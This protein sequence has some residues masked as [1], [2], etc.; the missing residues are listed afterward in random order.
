MGYTLEFRVHSISAIFIK[1][2]PNV[3]LSETMYRTYDSSM[4]TEGQGHT[5]R[6]CDLPLN[7]VSAI[8]PDP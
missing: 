2:H 1:L 8:S 7:F 5:S 4:Q 3:P 6:S